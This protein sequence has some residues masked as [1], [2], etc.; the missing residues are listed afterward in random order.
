MIS[1][2]ILSPYANLLKRIMR[3]EAPSFPVQKFLS[4]NYNDEAMLL[5][6]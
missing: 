4:R 3:V 1:S 2:L 6:A 5:K